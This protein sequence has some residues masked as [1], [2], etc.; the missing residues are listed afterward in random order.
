MSQLHR[1]GFLQSTAAGLSLSSLADCVAAA[2]PVSGPRADHFR[3]APFRFDVTP[4]MGHSCCGGWIKPIEAVDDS[5]EAIGYVLLG[6]GDPI[7]VCVVDWTGILNSAHTAWRAALAEAAGTSA[8]R[9]AVQCVHQHNAPFACLDAER[10]VAAEGDLPH[11]VELDFFTACLEKARHAVKTALRNPRTITHVGYGQAK[12][13]QVASN[14]RVHVDE[15]GKIIGMRGSA[16]TDAKLR[17]LPEGLI[18]P[19]LKTVAFFDG[20]QKVLA[21]HYYAVHPMSYYGDGRASSDFAGLA[22]KR[23]QD[24]EP[25]TTHLYFTGCS[26]NIAAGKYNDG[27]KPMRAV[28]TQRVYDGIVAS[29]SALQRESIRK[30]EWRATP[31]LPIPRSQ[32][33][34]QELKAA[35]QN[36]SNPVVGRNRPAY[37][38]AWHQRIEQKIPVILSS[39]SINTVSMIH[40]PAESFIEY[41]LRA[42]QLHPGR[43]VA[44]AAYGDGGSW[45]IPTKEAYP[46]GGYEVSVAFSEPMIDD[47]ITGAIRSL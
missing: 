22:R 40:L 34:V 23:R 15:T 27:S 25:G 28:L 8:E 42:Q 2:E 32:P 38:L 35:I 20:D 29:E 37:E 11:I 1:R 45:Y 43:F 44:T 13:E 3:I 5:L 14:R 30:I 17:D 6:A 12:V 36:K 21:C 26:G 31:I 39:L 33:G 47:E 4:P 10:I 46:G 24:D 16:C 7:V 19:F 9:V 18:D 41:Q